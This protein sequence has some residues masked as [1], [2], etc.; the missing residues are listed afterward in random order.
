MPFI[1]RKNAPSIRNHASAM[2]L[3]FLPF[4]TKTTLAKHVWILK[5]RN[6]DYQIKWEIVC[7]AAPFSPI[8]KKC[9]LC[10]AEKWH[11]VFKSESATL[12]KRQEIFN[13]C[14]HKESPLLVPKRLREKGSWDQMNISRDYVKIN[15]KT[16]MFL[17]CMETT[18]DW[19]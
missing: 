10:L 8:S 14:R 15:S 9:N 16:P 12:N 1:Y 11:I 4:W 5:D 18:E 19:C 3:E 2:F 7:R 6:E 17:S 13:H